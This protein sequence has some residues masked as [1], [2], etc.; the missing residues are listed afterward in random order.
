MA[1]LVNGPE[2]QAF[3]VVP[4]LEKCPKYIDLLTVLK[5]WKIS[6][7]HANEPVENLGSSW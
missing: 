1:S 3:P 7:I 2:K 6:E 4:T 5:I